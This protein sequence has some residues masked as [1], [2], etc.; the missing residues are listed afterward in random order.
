[1]GLGLSCPF[2]Q[3]AG[4]K[5]NRLRH[6]PL[7]A[8]ASASFFL[9]RGISNRL[10]AYGAPSL[11]RRWSTKSL[12]RRKSPFPCRLILQGAMCRMSR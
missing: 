11:N 10:Q 1:M 2:V 5:P 12:F 9:S 6:L 8:V 7:L 4:P 3:F